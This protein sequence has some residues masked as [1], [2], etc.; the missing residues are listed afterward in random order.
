MSLD[1]LNYLGKRLDGMDESEYKQF[2]AVLSCHEISEGWGLKNIINLTDNLTRF[3]LIKDTDDLEKVG[4]IHMLNVRGAL[5][6]S[7]YKIANGSPPRARSCWN[8]ARGSTRNTES[9]S[10]TRIFRLRKTSTA[11]RFR[12]IFTTARP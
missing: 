1:V 2:L 9:Y 3:T 12:R 7:E 6:E 8:P 4:L 10:L 11:Q 5:S